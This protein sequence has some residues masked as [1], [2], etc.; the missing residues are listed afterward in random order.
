MPLLVLFST[1]GAFFTMLYVNTFD[2]RAD[3][4]W[5]A[6]ENLW[7]DWSLHIAM[8]NVFALKDPVNW[9]SHHP[10]YAYGKFTYGFLTNF[11][12]GILMRFGV[13]L[14]DAF[15]LPS[16][17]YVAVL[18]TAMYTVALRLVK[19]RWW[20]VIAVSF[21]FLSS[22]FG[23]IDL[24]QQTMVTPEKV[25]FWDPPHNYSNFQN[26]DWYAGN[27]VVGML[28]P[29]RAFLLGLT[30]AMSALA[31]TLQV[32]L[33]PK[34]VAPWQLGI[35]AGAVAGLLPI[36][37]MHSFLVLIAVTGPLSLY[38][39]RSHWKYV[40][41]YSMTAGMLSSVLFLHFIHGGIQNPDFFT[42]LIG[43]SA[44]GY[45]DWFVMWSKFWGVMLLVA[46]VGLGIVWQSRDRARALVLSSFVS[47]FV[48]ANLILFQPIRWDNSKMFL[49]SYFGL[50]CLAVVVLQHVWQQKRLLW[51]QRFAVIFTVFLL[52]SGGVLD[53]QYLLQFDKHT[54]QMTSM[55]DIE[56]NWLIQQQ[57]D[58]NAVFATNTSHNHPVS[59]WGARP[60]MM[61]YSAWVANFGFLAG[62][63]EQALKSIFS[64]DEDAVAYIKH[65]NVSY[66]YFGPGERGFVDVPNEAFYQER[67]PVVF[68]NQNT[69]VYDVRS[70]W[71]A[72]LET[73][74]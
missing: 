53:L 58:Q 8:A 67:F 59:M 18:L 66:V 49:W 7:S 35:V 71:S 16:L 5:I 62:Q 54:Y 39:L 50:G 51:L 70:V 72:E 42:V 34:V 22:G 36:A 3:G 73:A 45:T 19:N 60:I 44:K 41:S 69:Q 68:S 56:M 25:Q 6:H 11:V 47:V 23:W 65:Y 13:N 20:A 28:W 26:Q 40:V 52:T 21:F 48:V 31:I 38:R 15:I 30:L 46:M 37:H 63:R 9:F 61:G 17:L 32:L 29:Q 1:W 33:R 24:V 12:S 57:T 10:H 2:I 43:W 64:G 74:N 55:D 4:V 27:V 14:V